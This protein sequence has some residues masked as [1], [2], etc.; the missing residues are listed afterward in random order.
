VLA[1]GTG[2]VTPDHYARV[3]KDLADV[4]QE[5]RQLRE[6]QADALARLEQLREMP[7]DQQPVSRGEMA[8]VGLRLE[9]MSRQI[10]INGERVTDLDRRLDTF[11][12]DLQ[13]TRELSRRQQPVSVPPPPLPPTTTGTAAAGS[14]ALPVEAGRGTRDAA[15]G[16][17]APPPDPLPDPESLYNTAYSDFSK[18]NYALA[19][20]G[21]DEYQQR[22]PDSDL[23]DNALY[24]IGECHFS[25]GDYA[26]AVE[27]FDHMLRSHPRSDKSAAANLKKALAFQEQNQIGQAI[28]QLRYVVTT[29]P[30]SDEARIA[31]DKLSGMGGG[32]A[33]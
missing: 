10:E 20:S 31:R 33:R 11:S 24:W 7:E 4:Q 6:E 18:G 25:Q 9:E 29:Y 12:Q 21:F 22:F 2:C 15:G 5:I 27:A 13:Q 26:R 30:D 32:G 23:A 8:D 14:S 28:V 17:P 19:I 1:A 16:P 3:Q